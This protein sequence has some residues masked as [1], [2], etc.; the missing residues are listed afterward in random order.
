[1]ASSLTIGAWSNIIRE[2]QNKIVLRNYLNAVQE[3]REDSQLVPTSTHD[4]YIIEE[5]IYW[6]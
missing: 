5:V 3:S 2:L 6:I 4:F 1:M